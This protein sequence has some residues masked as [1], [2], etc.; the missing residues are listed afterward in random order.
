MIP[1][2]PKVP[3]AAPKRPRGRPSDPELHERRRE[4][5]LAT[6]TGVFARL[7]YQSADVQFVAD[8]L[9][10][11]KGTVYRYFPTKEQLFLE[12]VRRGVRRLSETM[13]EVMATVPDPVD[14][15]A[16]STARY[17]RFFEANPDLVELFMQE[18]AEFREKRKPVYFEDGC[19]SECPWRET[20]EKLI[21]DG[22]FRDVPAER[23]MNVAGDLLYGTMFT[24]HIAGRS[25]SVE[26]QAEDIND[27]LFNGFL[28]PTERRRRA[29]AAGVPGKSTATK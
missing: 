11:S 9:K 15:L 7:G 18:R 26:E 10:V 12:A 21:A 6:A 1:A 23:V 3:P 4:E 25:R 5:I 22:R 2:Q 8:A 16:E 28:S 17:L 14:Q 20:I 27:V 19:S 13:D 24:N 29:R